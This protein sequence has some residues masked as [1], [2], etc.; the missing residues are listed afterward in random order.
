MKDKKELVYDL[1]GALVAIL[2]GCVVVIM[3]IA[4]LPNSTELDGALIANV[5][6]GGV[7]L[8]API[9]AYYLLSDWKE[10]F[11]F[12]KK[13]DFI[14]E[15]RAELRLLEDELFELRNYHPLDLSS[16]TDYLNYEE[17]NKDFNEAMQKY[18]S[19]IIK[20]RD[21]FEDLHFLLNTKDKERNNINNKLNQLVSYSI[22]A[23]R[24]HKIILS[25]IENKSEDVNITP[26]FAKCRAAY[27]SLYDGPDIET[28]EGK[29]SYDEGGFLA[30]NIKSLKDAYYELYEEGYSKNRSLLNRLLDR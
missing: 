1:A 12:S 11:K 23:K 22:L 16:L 27:D 25:A 7:T 9:A 20:I 15:I 2:F 17:K 28:T 14:L 30:N 19:H 26:S 8:F 5:L 24:A 18:L 4:N 3:V 6:V 13:V 29:L 21:I 10:Q